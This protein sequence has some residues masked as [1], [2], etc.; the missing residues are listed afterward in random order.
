MINTTNTINIDDSV[1]NDDTLKKAFSFDKQDRFTRWVVQPLMLLAGL[2]IGATMLF[3]SALFVLL[4]LALVPI[5]A[6]GLWAI[7]AKVQRDLAQHNPVVDTQRS[8]DISVNVD[9]Q[10]SQ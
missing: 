1:I 7:K 6:I 5:V 2:G 10:A 4:S 9:A 3:A 8:T